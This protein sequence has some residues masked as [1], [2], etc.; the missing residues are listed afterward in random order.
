MGGEGEGGWL[1]IN[2]GFLP[3]RSRASWEDCLRHPEVRFLSRLHHENIIRLLHAARVNGRLFLVYEQCDANLFQAMSSLQHLGRRLSEE[4]IR[5][6]MRRIL[7]GLDFLHSRNVIHRFVCERSEWAE[8]GR[9]RE[10]R[11]GGGERVA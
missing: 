11:E 4:Q 7:Q 3:F 8:Q 10:G 2:G 6:T 9:R 5:W 1:E